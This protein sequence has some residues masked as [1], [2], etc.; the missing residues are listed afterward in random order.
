M[1]K[2]CHINRIHHVILF[3]S[4]FSKSFEVRE[5]EMTRHM[6]AAQLTAQ[7]SVIVWDLNYNISARWTQVPMR[8][9]GQDCFLGRSS[10]SV[11]YTTFAN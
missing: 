7:Q 10:D 8:T 11:Y 1:T 6:K 4:H 2:P 3:P 5:R 9:P